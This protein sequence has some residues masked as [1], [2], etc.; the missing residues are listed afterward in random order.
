[1][2]LTPADLRALPRTT[3][4]V[5]DEDGRTLTYEGVLVGELLTRAGAPIG[6]ELRGNALATYVVASARDGYQVVFSL[7]ELDPAMTAGEIMVADTVDGK[8]LFDYQGPLRL[9]APRDKRGA[10]S[11]RLLERMEIVRLKNRRP[12]DDDATVVR[13]GRRGP[14][15]GELDGRPA[16]CS[17]ATAPRVERAG[18]IPTPPVPADDPLSDAKIELGRHLFYDRRLSANGTQSCST[19]HEQARAFT[20]GRARSLGSTG[21]AHPRGSMSLVNIAYAVVLTWANPTL[22]RLEDQALVPMYGE[23]PIE[24]GMSRSDVWLDSGQARCA[25]I[26]RW[27]ARHSATPARPGRGTT[28]SRRSPASNARSSPRVH[29]TT[30]I[31]TTV[32]TPRFR[33]RPGAAKSCS[34]AGRVL[35]H[36]PRR[37][38]LLGCHVRQRPRRPWTFEFHNTGL[39][40][41]AGALSFPAAN[42]GSTS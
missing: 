4:K 14:G 26:R 10:R 36:V 31:T 12:R 2:T 5:T 42:T 1:M 20:D 24:L 29:P 9:V 7:G 32:T 13:C 16:R 18:R 17:D 23:H 8:P 3:L 22:T 33:R 6:K 38:E 19:C 27:C 40:N 15:G 35:L 34:T 28:W 37:R 25:L 39:Y 41:L 11:V 21:Q 30:A